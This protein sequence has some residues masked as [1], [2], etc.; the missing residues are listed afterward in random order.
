MEFY[1][2]SIRCIYDCSSTAQA[3]SEPF[4]VYPTLRC[5]CF[6][7]WASWWEGESTHKP[8]STYNLPL[9]LKPRATS[10]HLQN[11]LLPNTQIYSSLIT[12][13]L[14]KQF[15]GS[16][17]NCSCSQPVEAIP[18]YLWKHLKHLPRQLSNVL[19]DVVCRT[20]FPLQALEAQM[21]LIL[22]IFQNTGYKLNMG[23]RKCF[24]FVF[25]CLIFSI[26][27]IKCC[28]SPLDGELAWAL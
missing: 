27:G 3:S 12:F 15:T 2:S 25:A 28:L 21:S 9:L 13:K 19:P 8:W 4:F 10:S 26:K 11:Q 20:T 14:L 1:F 7:M 22:I 6:S 24:L 5:I 18:Y 17:S 16:V 23:L